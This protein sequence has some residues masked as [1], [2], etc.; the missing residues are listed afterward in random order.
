[1]IIPNICREYISADNKL[2][3][4]ASCVAGALFMTAVDLAARTATAAEIPIGI[5]TAVIGAPVFVFVF[6]KKEETAS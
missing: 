6:F 3:I 2:L 4:P 1:M 5:L